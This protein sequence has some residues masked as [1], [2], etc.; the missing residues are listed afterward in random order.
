MRALRLRIKA[1]LHRVVFAILNACT[2]SP[3]LLSRNRLLRFFLFEAIGRS[4]YRGLLISDNEEAVFVHHSRDRGPGRDLFIRGT[5]DFAKYE[6]ACRLLQEN[7]VA[8]IATLLD[9]GANIGTICIPAVKR[10][11]A[12][13][14]IAIEAVP[15][16]AR[17][18][19]ANVILND[20]ASAITVVVAAVSARAGETVAMAVQASNQGD[21]RVRIVGEGMP[22]SDSF[23]ETVEVVSTTVD[24]LLKDGAEGV[25]IWMDIQ[26]HEGIALG[27]APRTL[28]LRP[29]LVLEFCPRLMHL[30][31]SFAALKSA[32]AGY[33]GFYDLDC[34][35][36]LQPVAALDLLYERLGMRGNFTDILLV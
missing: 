7:G 24:D 29:P 4:R 33:R 18:L 10:G 22:D 26:G 31:G 1:A 11:L 30:G 16:I 25:L 6:V 13:R 5:Q 12:G 28:A 2:V 14:A 20:L 15:A 23:T 9:V 35:S 21:N 36:A 19:Q 27:G 3:L 34:P 17:L 32:V 8:R